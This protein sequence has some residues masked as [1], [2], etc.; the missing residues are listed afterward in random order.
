MRGLADAE[1]VDTLLFHLEGV[2]KEEVKLRPTKEEVKLRPTSEWSSP[3]GVF[4]ILREALS[5]QLT[6]TQARRKFFAKQQG[7]R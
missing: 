2:V 6:E 1:A 7:D 4:Q 5:E 3:S